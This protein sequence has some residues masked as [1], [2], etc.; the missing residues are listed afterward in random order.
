MCGGV[1]HAPSGGRASRIISAEMSTLSGFGSS[2]PPWQTSCQ[3][4]LSHC[5]IRSCLE[6]SFTCSKQQP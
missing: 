5:C 6:S 1:L 2:L 4:E 3:G